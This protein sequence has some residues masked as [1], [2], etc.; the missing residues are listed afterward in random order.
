MSIISTAVGTFP[1][2]TDESL[3]DYSLADINASSVTL[4]LYGMSNY[5][6]QDRETVRALLWEDREIWVGG[7]CER[8]RGHRCVLHSCLCM[9]LGP[10]TRTNPHRNNYNLDNHV[11]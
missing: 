9:S 7:G 8:E 6:M 4:C 3:G 10:N 11:H 1:G 2:Y 5:Y